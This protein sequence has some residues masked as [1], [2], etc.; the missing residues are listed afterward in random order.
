MSIQDIVLK[1]KGRIGKSR[2][3][4]AR[5]AI[6]AFLWL[7]ILVFIGLACFFAGKTSSYL[8]SSKPDPI[9]II[10]PPQVAV[11]GQIYPAKRVSTAV[12]RDDTPTSQQKARKGAFAGSKTGKMYYPIDCKGLNRVKAEN[13]V[14]FATQAQA[15][16]AGYSI[17]KSCTTTNHP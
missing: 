17:S 3:G 15:R 7:G 6:Q 16:S 11:T 5:R 8:G 12:S 14:Y 2:L 9:S 4:K 1:I 10:Y 13:R